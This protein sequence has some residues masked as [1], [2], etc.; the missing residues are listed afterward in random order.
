MTFRRA[1]PAMCDVAELD[2]D[3]LTP[4]DYSGLVT[5]WLN[6]NKRPT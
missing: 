6:E 3:E 5:A 4:A 2:P 1:I